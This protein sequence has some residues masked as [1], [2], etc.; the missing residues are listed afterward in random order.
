MFLCFKEHIY[1]GAA[2][3]YGLILRPFMLNIQIYLLSSACM[4]CCYSSPPS[5]GFGV[6]HVQEYASCTKSFEPWLQSWLCTYHAHCVL[7]FC[8]C[9]TK[10]LMVRKETLQC[11]RKKSITLSVLAPASWAE[12]LRRSTLAKSAPEI[13]GSIL[14]GKSSMVGILEMSLD[15]QL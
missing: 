5:L 13:K 14:S 9:I 2:G 15:G 7:F 11:I 4:L 12:H 10:P 6:S 1:G 3:R 8:Q